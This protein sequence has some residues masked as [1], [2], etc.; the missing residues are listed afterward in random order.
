MADFKKCVSGNV[1]KN[2]TVTK[3]Y[4]KTKESDTCDSADKRYISEI[5]EPCFSKYIL[6]INWNNF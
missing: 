2:I 3:I 1:N 5:W 6:I 4:I